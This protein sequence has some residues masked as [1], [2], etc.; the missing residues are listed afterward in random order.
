MTIALGL[1]PRSPVAARALRSL[2]LNVEAVS[3]A[4]ETPEEKRARLLA[5]RRILVEAHLCRG[6][7]PAAARVSTR[8]RLEAVRA[9]LEGLR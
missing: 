9:D 6:A 7:K 2:G 8:A 3:L 4:R 1:A 5:Q